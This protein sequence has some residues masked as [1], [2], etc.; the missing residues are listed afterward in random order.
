MCQTNTS[1]LFGTTM[2]DDQISYVSP[3]ETNWQNN[4]LD[5][6]TATLEDMRFEMSEIMLFNKPLSDGEINM[7][8]EMTPQQVHNILS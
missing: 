8:V 6:S 3:N 2:Q 1:L 4:N 7:M 5:R